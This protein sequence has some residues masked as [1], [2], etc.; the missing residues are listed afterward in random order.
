[1]INKRVIRRSFDHIINMFITAKY[2]EDVE[3]FLI[4]HFVGNHLEYSGE[5]GLFNRK[6]LT[7]TIVKA[8]TKQN[9]IFEA[10]KFL[11]ATDSTVA[12]IME[13]DIKKKF[14]KPSKPAGYLQKMRDGRGCN[15]KWN[16]KDKAGKMS[17]SF[18]KGVRQY[19]DEFEHTYA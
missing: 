9:I 15:R 13:S 5:V 8:T 7:L 16:S 12:S 19:D 6:K 17:L 1:M 11:G 2:D 14:F 10:A 18:A 4:Q 3:F